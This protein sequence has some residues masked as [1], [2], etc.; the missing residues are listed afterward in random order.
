MKT[1]APHIMTNE[2]PPYYFS[3]SEQKLV[4]MS[5]CSFGIYELY[6]FYKN[7]EL[8]M[9]RTGQNIF[10][11]VRAIFPIFF[12]HSL[13]ESVKESAFAL[14]IPSEIRPRALSIAWVLLTFGF[15]SLPNPFWLVGLLTFL[16]MLPVQKVINNINRKIAPSAEVNDRFTGKNIAVLILGGISVLLYVIGAFVSQ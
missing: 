4:V 9:E 3:V 13:F 2:S 12:C 16:P 11:L 1:G 5:L 8:I 10:P 14:Q 15:W 7:W 6:W